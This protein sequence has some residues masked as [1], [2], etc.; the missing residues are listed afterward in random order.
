[1]KNY[2]RKKPKV[3]TASNI[4]KKI[5]RA[6]LLF[7]FLALLITFFFGDHGLYHLYTLRAET[8]KVQKYLVVLLFLSNFYITSLGYASIKNSLAIC[9]FFYSFYYVFN[10]K[11]EPGGP[12]KE[13]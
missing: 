3:K 9:L 4:Q 12:F 1:M 6:V 13:L 11:F 2:S 10:Q 8:N 7:G 5:I